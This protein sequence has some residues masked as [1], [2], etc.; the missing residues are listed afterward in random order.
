VALLIDHQAIDVAP[1]SRDFGPATI[2]DG[3]TRVT[4]RLA[5]RTAAAPT[6][7]AAGVRVT[8]LSWCSL[9][10]GATWAKWLGFGEGNG[11]QDGG[12]IPGPLGDLA[13]SWVSAALP[14]GTS[15]RIKLTATVT[16]GTL[17]SA[18][19]VEVV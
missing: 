8:L 15:R 18:L 9:D 12:V 6:L 5:R 1:G 2:P 7:W 19:T 16:G 17:V 14:V 13:E 10:G 3:L 4:L 11:G